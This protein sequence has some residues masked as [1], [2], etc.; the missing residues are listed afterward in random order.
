MPTWL[1]ELNSLRELEICAISRLVDIPRRT[2][3]NDGCH[4]EEVLDNDYNWPWLTK[5]SLTG[6][7]MQTANLNSLFIGCPRLKS[8]YIGSIDLWKG[9]WQHI[10]ELLRHKGLTDFGFQRYANM[11]HLGGIPFDHSGVFEGKPLVPEAYRRSIA[12]YVVNGGRHPSLPLNMPSS[13][14]RYYLDIE[15]AEKMTR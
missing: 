15:F 5:L 14:S 9:T 2:T 1:G 12:E 3:Y 7:R 4:I 13:A 11:R 10:I 8:V 6:I